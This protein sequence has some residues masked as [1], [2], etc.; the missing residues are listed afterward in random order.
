[1]A[2]IVPAQESTGPTVHTVDTLTVHALRTPATLGSIPY[3]VNQIDVSDIVRDGS[4]RC[5]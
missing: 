2:T 3:S 1:M 4:Q 5:G